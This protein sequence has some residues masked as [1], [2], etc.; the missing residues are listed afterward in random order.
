MKLDHRS[1]IFQNLNGATGK[2]SYY[3]DIGMPT[4]F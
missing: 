2:L 4:A 3:A 1:H